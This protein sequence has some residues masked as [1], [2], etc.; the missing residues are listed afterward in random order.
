MSSDNLDALEEAAITAICALADR[1]QDP[2]KAISDYEAKLTKLPPAAEAPEAK[3]ET[4]MVIALAARDILER[5][6]TL[7]ATL[8]ENGQVRSTPFSSLRQ[9][10][11]E[12]IPG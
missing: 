2:D 11:R 9:A 4:Q 5:M 3:S 6:K 7:A 8:N 12:V 10:A 1:K